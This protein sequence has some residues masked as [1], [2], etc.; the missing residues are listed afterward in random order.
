ML[1][2]L[3]KTGHHCSLNFF[4]KPSRSIQLSGT[5]FQSWFKCRDG[6]FK[7]LFHFIFFN[8]FPIHPL[9]IDMQRT[10]WTSQLW[11]PE[12]TCSDTR[13]CLGK[14]GSFLERF[15]GW[16]LRGTPMKL[17]QVLSGLEMLWSGFDLPSPHWG[18]I[19]IHTGFWSF[20]SRF[21]RW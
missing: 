9:P 15:P 6:G 21:S 2:W 8:V 1:A 17:S 18:C 7:Q 3:I 11:A 4:M 20:S 14:R 5:W 13:K 10:I 16:S 12:T 19:E